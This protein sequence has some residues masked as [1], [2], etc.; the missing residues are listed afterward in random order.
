M[1]AAMSAL[2]LTEWLIYLNLE[3]VGEMRA[4][5]R[6][7]MVCATVANYAGKVRKEGADAAVPADFM[8]ALASRKNQ[9]NAGD[10]LLMKTPEEQAELIKQ[11]LFKGL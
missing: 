2:Q 9:S 4:D 6:A 3:P 10:P 5:F 1:T 7:G 8:P 11:T